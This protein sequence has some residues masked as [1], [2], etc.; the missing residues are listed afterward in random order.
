MTETLIRPTGTLRAWGWPLLAAGI[1]LIVFVW[2]V[3]AVGAVAN[4]FNES[5]REGEARFNIAALIAVA[6]PIAGLA[7]LATGITLLVIA[8]KRASANREATQR[9]V[10]ESQMQA[11]YG[12]LPPA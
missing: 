1:L 10:I 8:G 7:A 6:A 11:R 5:F 2:P 3:Y 9:A 4:D 12:Q